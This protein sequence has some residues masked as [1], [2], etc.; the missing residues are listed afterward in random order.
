MISVRSLTSR[1]IA[2][3]V[4]LQFPLVALV[5]VAV[6][7]NI[8]PLEVTVILFTVFADWLSVIVTL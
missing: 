1:W 3:A 6:L 4:P 5:E 8:V 7:D 2:V